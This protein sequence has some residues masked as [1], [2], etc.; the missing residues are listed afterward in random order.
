MPDPG[1][2]PLCMREVNMLMRR[3]S[4]K[5]RIAFVDIASPD[6]DPKQNAN[7]SFE[8]VRSTNF[9]MSSMIHHVS[10]TWICTMQ[11]SGGWDHLHN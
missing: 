10:A 9:C 8:E 3:D 5:G 4:E 1:D 7:I 11:F 6:Y 2:C